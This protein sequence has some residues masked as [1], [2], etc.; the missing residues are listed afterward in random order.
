VCGQASPELVCS[1]CKAKIQAEAVDHKRKDEKFSDR[2]SAMGPH[3]H[4]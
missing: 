1:S 4:G 3:N 2:G